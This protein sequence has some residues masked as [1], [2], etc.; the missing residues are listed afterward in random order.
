MG[1]VRTDPEKVLAQL[2]QLDVEPFQDRL[3]E[4]LECFPDKESI[5]Q[6]AQK[7]PDRYIQGLVM[8]CRLSGYRQD[9]PVV[10]NNTFVMI[11]GMSDSDLHSF[12]ARLDKERRQLMD[13]TVDGSVEGQA[14]VSVTNPSENKDLA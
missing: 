3:A 5:R 9:S 7:H 10:Q 4:Y 12:M 2:K 6:A 14:P 13:R 8:L 1:C 11:Q